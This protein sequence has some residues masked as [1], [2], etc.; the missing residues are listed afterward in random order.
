MFDL[1]QLEKDVGAVVS[2]TPR[3][4]SDRLKRNDETVDNAAIGNGSSVTTGMP[5]HDGTAP[6]LRK[7]AVAYNC[8]VLNQPAMGWP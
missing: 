3:S 1:P 2:P 4:H 5:L 7:N 8:T 6:K